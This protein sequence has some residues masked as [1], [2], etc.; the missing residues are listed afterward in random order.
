MLKKILIGL[1]IFLF[2]LLALYMYASKKPMVVVVKHTFH[3]PVDKVWPLW[4][5]PE[6]I[7]R[8][9]GPDGYSAPVVKNDFRVGGKYLLSMRGP[10]GKVAYNVG[11]YTQI[12]PYA[13]IVSRMAFSD[14]HGNAVPAA[15]YGIPGEWNEDI[16]VVVDF[17]DLGDGRTQVMITESEIP[18]IMSLFAQMGW[19]QQFEKFD[20]LLKP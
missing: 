11:T 6:M 1:G 17:F 19:K 20:A 5:D 18:L 13:K 15:H 7:K 16:S 12:V 8:W 2:I 14:E 10:D 9:W 3:A 4:Q